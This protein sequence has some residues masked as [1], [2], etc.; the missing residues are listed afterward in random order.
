[1]PKIAGLGSQ[2]TGRNYHLA[3]N[4]RSRRNNGQWVPFGR[5]V[6]TSGNLQGWI[7][8]AQQAAD[9]LDEPFKNVSESFNT[10]YSLKNDSNIT[11]LLN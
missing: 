3:Q 9:E 10:I 1:M 8:N 2:H 6:I 7:H 4:Y 11:A 5:Q